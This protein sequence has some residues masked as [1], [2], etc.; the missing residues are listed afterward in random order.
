MT[1]LSKAKAK[2]N[3]KIEI[4]K[5]KSDIQLGRDYYTK[6]DVDWKLFMYQGMHKVKNSKSWKPNVFIAGNL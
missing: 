1:T 2:K 6:D 4:S 5:F 3:A